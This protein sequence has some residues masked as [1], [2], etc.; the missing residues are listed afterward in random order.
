MARGA[1]FGRLGNRI[2]ARLCVQLDGHL[3]L[4]SDKLR[5]TLENVSRTGAAIRTA[6]ALTPGA[7]CLLKIGNI[8]IFSVVAWTRAGRTGLSFE[9]PLS[10]EQ[11]ELLQLVAEDPHAFELQQLRQDPRHWR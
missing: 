5:I 9:K 2:A 4:A 6:A 1:S 10:K 3:D 7:S 11:M 8:A